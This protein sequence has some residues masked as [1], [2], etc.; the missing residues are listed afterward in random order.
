VTR[1]EWHQRLSRDQDALSMLFDINFGPDWVDDYGLPWT[2][3][4]DGFVTEHSV[5]HVRATLAEL[6]DLLSDP[7]SEADLRW[8]LDEVVHVAFDWEHR[9]AGFGTARA[10]LEALRDELRRRTPQEA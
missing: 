6:G 10:W 9:D 5:G 4:V 3:A 7:L 8:L 1:E 2:N